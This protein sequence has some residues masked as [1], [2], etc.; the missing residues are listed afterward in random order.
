VLCGGWR[1]EQWK[2]NDAADPTH[3]SSLLVSSSWIPTPGLGHL[4][5]RCSAPSRWAGELLSLPCSD[6][7][8]VA[9]SSAA[10]HGSS[11]TGKDLA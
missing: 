7:A 5:C 1:A 9:S 8:P 11:N 4:Y 3:S 6:Q 10:R 2:K